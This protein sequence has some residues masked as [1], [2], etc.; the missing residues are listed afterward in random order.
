M[1]LHEIKS[2]LICRR[3][4]LLSTPI[5][6]IS[7]EN[8][9]ISFA[10]NSIYDLSYNIIS[11]NLW[12]CVSSNTVSESVPKTLTENNE[13]CDLLFVYTTFQEKDRSTLPHSVPEY[14][15][16]QDFIY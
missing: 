5:S 13:I 2:V 15:F 10:L 6:V 9:P 14:S 3:H 8:S 1:E 11:Y 7:N 16:I 12:S 4:T